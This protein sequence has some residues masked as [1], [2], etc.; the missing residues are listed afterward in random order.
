MMRRHVLVVGAGLSGATVARCL[1][2]AGCFVDVIDQRDHVAGN[3]H[4]ER[5]AEPGVLVH[6]Y[7][8]HIFHTNNRDVWDFVGRFAH[9]ERYEHRVKTRIGAR[10]YGLPIN[11]HTL[12]QFFEAAFSPAQARAFLCSLCC[13]SDTA[14]PS[15]ETRARASVGQEIYE[16]FY[17]GYTTKQWGRH[18]REIP[19]SVFARLPIRFTY[20]DRY[21]DHRF[22]AM[23]RDGYTHLVASMLDHPDVKVS[24]NTPFQR[25]M[26]RGYDHL[27]YT[28][29]ID[30][31]FGQ[32]E[33]TLPYRT[34]DF[35]HRVAAGD[36]QGCAV[37][38][39]ADP[40]VPYTRITEHKHFA[41]WE[42]HPNTVYTQEFARDAQEG[43]I[44]FYPLRGV[45]GLALLNHYVHRA[46]QVRNTTFLGRLGTYRYLDMDV[47]IQEALRAAQ[48]Y[49][50][51]TDRGR[52][53]VLFSKSPI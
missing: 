45:H 43:D 50:V 18:P 34:L 48:D 1:A 4:T 5:D 6:R 42:Q 35:V 8:P 52:Q 27:F 17:K 12:N 28:G 20:D 19:A 22:Q 46:K 44:L 39:F 13:V 26:G 14:T 7:G 11:L 53:P 38:N 25:A 32:E 16:A 31:F 9:F 15:F 21:F 36:Y 33:G 23:P 49:L 10:V 51:A 37:M 24:L 47:A 2:D 3:C 30:G 40:D 41:P 29:S